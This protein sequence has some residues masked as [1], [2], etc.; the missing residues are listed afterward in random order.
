MKFFFFFS[1]LC[2][3]PVLKGCCEN[4]CSS[5]G[6]C[7]SGT[8]SC[9]CFSQF[10]GADCSFRKCPLGKQWFGPAS[11]DDDVHETL[12]ECSG[13]GECDRTTGLCSCNNGFEG[14]S[15]ER[16]SCPNDCN[17][18]GKCVSL[19]QVALFNDDDLYFGEF[20]Y[21]QWDA[22]RIFLCVCDYGFSGRD[23]G[24]KACHHGDDPVTTS[25]EVDEVQ[26]IDCVC[27][28]DCT[29]TFALQFKQFITN[30]INFDDSSTALISVLEDLPNI[31]KISVS[32]ATPTSL[33]N[34]AGVSTAIT[35]THNAGN[36][37]P[38]RIVNN[39]LDSVSGSVSISVSHAGSL[40]LDGTVSIVGNK[41]NLECN[42]RGK[43]SKSTGLCTCL[44]GYGHSDGAGNDG[45]MQDCG[46]L[47]V[48]ETD[49]PTT[50]V[51]DC[52]GMGVC[53]GSPD[54]LCTCYSGYYG[55]DCSKKEC[56]KGK[57]W[58]SS[59]G[60][61]LPGTLTV[62]NGNSFI[63]SSEDL[64][65]FLNRGDMIV[66]EKNLLTI[67][68]VSSA[69]FSSSN[70]PLTEP[71]SGES[72]TN[73][74]GVHKRN[75]AHTSKECSNRGDCNDDGTCSCDQ[76][77]TGSSCERIICPSACNSKGVC[78]SLKERAK[79]TKVNG[80]TQNYLYGETPFEFST[81][82]HDMIY[83][84]LCD[85]TLSLGGFYDFQGIA[86]GERFCT[87]G[88]DPSLANIE[89]FAKLEIQQMTCIASDGAFSL[90]FRDQSSNL[91]SFDATEEELQ[92]EI[93]SI[94]SVGEVDITFS[95]GTTACSESPGTTIEIQFLT[96]LGDLPMFELESSL[97]GTSSGVTI[98][99]VQAGTR[100]GYECS[101]HGLCN[102]QTGVCECFTGYVSSDGKGKR[103]LK[104][105][106]SFRDALFV[107]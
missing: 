74:R 89:S 73:V 46:Y 95:P 3:F 1:F 90:T 51:T 60:E 16:M 6:T 35:F 104:G 102:R 41:E 31:E 67:A 87:I 85:E 30:S 53:S 76:G 72:F 54:F 17:S 52:S 23:C 38:L 42:G 8:C 33:C 99:E 97:S 94:L 32:S 103:G 20:A 100:V 45:Y 101:N 18:N 84:C 70:V 11:G 50:T 79:R 7:E 25:G 105:D 9:S 56:P 96:D 34:V 55:I 91:I 5:H 86:C 44:T 49:C 37:P 98:V 66:L 15:C 40:A 77:F 36:L 12:T 26:I 68:T 63:T 47:E 39:A 28:S 61:L 48:P 58:Y 93:E 14:I 92:K 24:N 69:T 21:D 10:T 13:M 107:S 80:V 88:E 62:E 64:R 75:E 81:W 57:A 71:Y 43:C 82:D 78:M 2:L 65:V 106:C 59:P 22:D 83:G 19:R 4:G 29:G 27:P